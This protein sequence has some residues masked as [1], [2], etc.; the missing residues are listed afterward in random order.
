MLVLVAWL[1]AADLQ[2]VRSTQAPPQPIA[3]RA[4]TV[5]AEAPEVDELVVNPSKGAVEPGWSDKLNF[6]IRG[7]YAPLKQPFL[8]RRPASG[9]KA[10]AG[11]ATSLIG[12]NGVAGGVVCAW[13]F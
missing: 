7:H 2:D 10:M 9:C 5:K 13:R 6:D 12:E 11:G 8:R 4:S 3:P 1:A